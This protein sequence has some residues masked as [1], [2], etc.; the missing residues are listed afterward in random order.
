MILRSPL[1]AAPMIRVDEP[2]SQR[3][4]LMEAS[5]HFAARPGNRTFHASWVF[6]SAGLLHETC[7]A[8]PISTVIK[9]IQ[10]V[11]SRNS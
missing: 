4:K 10:R 6:R 1:I 8:T 3:R 2:A 9:P 11:S 5:T 7:R